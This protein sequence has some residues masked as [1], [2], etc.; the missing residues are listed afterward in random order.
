MGLYR[1]PVKQSGVALIPDAMRKLGLPVTRTDQDAHGVHYF[2]THPKRNI[3]LQFRLTAGTPSFLLIGVG[4]VSKP[5]LAAFG[6]AGILEHPSGEPGAPPNGG[7]A[8]PSDNS[9]TG[10][11]PPSV[12]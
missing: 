1:I 5:I 10:G 7:P 2:F 9:N 4:R 11:G 8:K 12:S 6:E 3:E